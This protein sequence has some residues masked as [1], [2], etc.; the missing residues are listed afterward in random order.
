MD[1]GNLTIKPV[2]IDSLETIVGIYKNAIKNMETNNIYQWDEFYPDEN[3]LKDDILK[4]GC[5]FAWE[6]RIN[7]PTN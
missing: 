5:K 3:C 1:K 6:R 7:S 4:C 2:K